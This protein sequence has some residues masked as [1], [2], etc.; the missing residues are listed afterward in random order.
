M[1][2][3]HQV[4]IGP[5]DAHGDRAAFPRNGGGVRG[6]AVRIDLEAEEV[7]TLADS[8]PEGGRVFPDPSGE[9]Q[10]VQ[11]TQDGDQGAQIF[12]GLIT[13]QGDGFGGARPSPLFPA[14]RASPRW[15][16]KLRAARPAG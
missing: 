1:P 2:G 16:P 13:E 14:S 7:Q 5:Q 10:G 11:A 6:V 12:P 15:F 3:D 4:F 8:E 9:D